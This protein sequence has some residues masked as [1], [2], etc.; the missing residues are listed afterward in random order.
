A[1]GA[2]LNW[3]NPVTLERFLWHLSGKQFRVWIFSSTEAAGRQLKYFVSSLPHEFAYIGLVLASVG[4]IAL[5][6]MNR[7]LAIGVLLMFI[8]CVFYSINYD[9]HD[10]D[11]YFL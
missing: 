1:K 2:L 7:K 9:I 5:L 6:H 4:V 8:S 11:S 10:I 3:G